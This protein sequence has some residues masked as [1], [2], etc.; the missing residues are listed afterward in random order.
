MLW[1]F[2]STGYTWYSLFHIF[3]AVDAIAYFFLLDRKYRSLSFWVA[4]ESRLSSAD[5]AKNN[6]VHNRIESKHTQDQ[7]FD[8]S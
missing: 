2:S 8:F 7:K 3:R 4:T 6:K 5:A 1:V